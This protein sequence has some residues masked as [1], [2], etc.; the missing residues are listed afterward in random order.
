MSLGLGHAS[1]PSGEVTASFRA[2]W[3]K[4]FRLVLSSAGGAALVLGVFSLF[5]KQPGESFRLL[6][7]WGP[8]PVIALVALM[9][10]GSFLSKISEI[11]QTAFGAIVTSSQRQ[12]DSGAKMADA[13]SQLAEQGGK[14]VQEVQRLAIYAAQEFPTIYARLDRQD[15]VLADHGKTLAEIAGTMRE[16]VGGRHGD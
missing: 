15:A 8:W 10:L 5:E 12:A 3:V 7:A 4:R 11:I 14:Q 16:L 2:G 1:V 9:L 13:V 6:G